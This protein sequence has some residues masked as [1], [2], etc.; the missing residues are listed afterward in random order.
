MM[1]IPFVPIRRWG[2]VALLTVS[3]LFPTGV[4]AAGQMF[5]DW[6]AGRKFNELDLKGTAI[7]EH[8]FLV[9]GLSVQET[10][11]TGSEVCWRVVSDGNGGFYTGTGHAGELYHTDKHGETSVFARF[12]GAEV[13]SLAVLPSGELLVGCGP[14]GQ[15]YGV[16]ARGESELLGQVPGGY[17][18]AIETTEDGS[19][20]WLA[21]GSPARIYKYTATGGLEDFV[22]FPAQ[23]VLDL[24]LDRDGTLLASTQ[25]PG[26]VYRIDPKSPDR[27][28]LICETS[29]DEVR[30]F[31]RGP[32]DKVFF[33]ALNNDSAGN[34]E[35]DSGL[36]K[37]GGVPPSL[38]SLFGS[39]EEPVVEKAALFRLEDENRF[40]P[41]WSGDLDLMIVAWSSDWGW[42]GGGPISTKEASS[43]VRHLT[44]PAGH[45]ILAAWPGG[46]ILDLM[47]LNE[48]ELLVS[49]AHPGGVQRLGRNGDYPLVAI[50]P[51]LDGGGAVAWGRLNWQAVEGAG[52]PRWSVR[53]GNR[54]VPDESWTSWTDSWTEESHA[55]NIPD[56]RF[57]Q[58]RVELPE[59]QKNSNKK[60]QITSVSV[61]AWRKNEP[62][63]I[64]NFTI[65]NISDISRGGLVGMGENVTQTFESGL[66]VEFGRTSSVDN[67]AEP[68]RAAFTRAVRV[69]TWQG[70]DSN[71]DRLVYG[72]EYRRQGEKSWRT[73]VEKS[74]E[75]LGSWDTSGVADGL[76]NLRV[77]ANDY[78]DNPGELALSSSRETGP[79]LVDNTPPEITRFKLEKLTTGVLVSFRARDKASVLAQAFVRLPDGREQRLD[80]VDRICDSLQEEFKYEIPWPV[81]SRPSGREPWQFR[82]EVWDL[83]GNA[84]VAEG[85]TR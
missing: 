7:S 53:C 80:P 21:T 17:I 26:L 30:Q 70:T 9:P 12:D 78:L 81:E 25:G 73:I 76:Y 16:D 34:G 60:L 84:A 6:P 40:S 32:E 39:P 28:R 1:S 8:G 48:Q 85:E 57:V 15:F 63:V 77:T 36:G 31:I 83:N 79:L 51:S 33:L 66:K 54:S 82:V 64:R 29:Q 62:P 61:S 37:N 20:A 46:D 11:P 24:M 41:F 69:M 19:T 23:N 75:Q 55:L 49:Q 74:P 65:E 38:L 67:K 10:G 5:W 45:H 68:R 52:K 43:V 18:W 14:D 27:P 59:P 56:S 72:L 58:W 13:F 42:V 44:A 3:I 2:L 22:T 4:F 47:A 71:S 35:A 50:S